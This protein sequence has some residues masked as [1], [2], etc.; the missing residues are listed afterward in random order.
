VAKATV[1]KVFPRTLGH[2]R[3]YRTTSAR[4]PLRVFLGG[5]ERTGKDPLG[6]STGPKVVTGGW[7]RPRKRI[8]YGVH[9]PKEI[10]L[11]VI[12]EE[13]VE[14]TIASTFPRSDE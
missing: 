8:V 5:P 14:Q 10:E 6:L 11:E 4:P 1:C 7:M 12:S 9:A 2:V 13:E 3:R